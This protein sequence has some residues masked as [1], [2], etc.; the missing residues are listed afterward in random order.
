MDGYLGKNILV[1]AGFGEAGRLGGVAIEHL[2]DTDQ[3]AAL[4]EGG[5]GE[6]HAH[7]VAFC[8]VG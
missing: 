8:V 4:V 3:D 2:A 6:V 5:D 7:H 1:E